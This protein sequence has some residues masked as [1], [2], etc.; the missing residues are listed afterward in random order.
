MLFF[1]QKKIVNRTIGNQDNGKRK[2]K[3]MTI[4]S[5]WSKKY[6]ER[7]TFMYFILI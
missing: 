3:N 5:V 2:L 4:Q 7:V 6:L 1:N